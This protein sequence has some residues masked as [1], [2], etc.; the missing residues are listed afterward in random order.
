MRMEDQIILDI[1]CLI[2]IRMRTKAGRMAAAKT[3]CG[4]NW[5]VGEPAGS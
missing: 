3:Q 2:H 1:D 4:R 5:F